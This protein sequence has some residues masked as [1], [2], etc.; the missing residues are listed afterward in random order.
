MHLIGI[1]TSKE[2]IIEKPLSVHLLNI[3]H[4][5]ALVKHSGFALPRPPSP[6]ENLCVEKWRPGDTE[7]ALLRKQEND[8]DGT[9][10][11]IP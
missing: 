11:Y 2:L 8:D 6:L 5:T 3:I 9:G 10:I 4:S 7:L 1:I